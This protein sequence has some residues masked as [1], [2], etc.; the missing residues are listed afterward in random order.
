MAGQN[1]RLSPEPQKFQIFSYLALAFVGGTISGTHFCKKT[2]CQEG[3]QG[4]IRAKKVDMVW[5]T[6]SPQSLSKCAS[7]EAVTV[8]G[9]KFKGVTQCV[10]PFYHGR[11]Q[12]A[13]SWLIV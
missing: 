7:I 10:P 8:F 5:I 9:N 13:V 11:R 3:K 4:A 12:M 2:D 6:K 1:Q